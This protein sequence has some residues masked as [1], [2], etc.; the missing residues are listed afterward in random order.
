MNTSLPHIPKAERKFIWQNI[1]V[2]VNIIFFLMLFT[3]FIF[4][5]SR[6]LNYLEFLFGAFFLGELIIS[7][8]KAKPKWR[9]LLSPLTIIDITTI[10]IILYR[11]LVA[12]SDILHIISSLRIFRAYI[13]FYN[14]PKFGFLARNRDIL[15][16]GLNL[17]VFIFI[18][19]TVIFVFQKGSNPN[20]NSFVDAMYFTL[21]TLTTTGFGDIT[22]VGQGGKI[23]ASIIMVFG[24]A[25]FLNLAT[26]IFRPQKSYYRC[27][28]C[29]LTRHDTDAVHCKHC[30]RI[31]HIETRGEV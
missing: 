25:L 16:A 8:K 7:L 23:L 10:G 1:A 18:M 21:S 24:V 26:S 14:L 12:D 31:V 22:V 29:G 2:G 9:F 17:L 13:V 4:P 20:I 30:G 11:G 15:L 5:E 27:K 6:F 28:K 19:T 3:E